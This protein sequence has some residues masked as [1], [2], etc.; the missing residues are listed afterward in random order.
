MRLFSRPDGRYYA[1]FDPEPDLLGDSVI[2]TIHGS[3]YSKLGGVFTYLASQVSTAQLAAQR[4]RHGYQEIAA[5]G[6]L[7]ELHN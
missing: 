3:H 5:E 1:V 2:L 4:I 7:T 6:S